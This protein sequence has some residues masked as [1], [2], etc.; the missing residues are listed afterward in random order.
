MKKALLKGLFSVLS[1][2]P[3]MLYVACCKNNDNNNRENQ[4]KIFVE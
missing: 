4:D 2:I 1:A 3:F